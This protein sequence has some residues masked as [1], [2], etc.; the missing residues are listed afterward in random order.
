M[1]TYP[2]SIAVY[3][4]WHETELERWLSDNN[5]PYPTPA[6][7]KDLENL[8]E[9]NWNDYVVEP[10]TNWDVADLSAYLQAKG[11]QSQK[12]V[13]QTKDKLVTQVKENWY[14][15]EEHAQQAYLSIKDWILD[16][17]TESQLKAFC[18]KNGIPAPQPR[19][20]DTLLLKARSSYEA[21]AKKLGETAAY[22]GNWLWAAW[23][24]SEL[25]AW[26]DT[27]G[28]PA[29]Q[30]S[31]RD[32][33]VAS[34]R[35]NSRLAYL[36][37][38]DAAASATA[39]A[40]A[41]YATLTDIIID[42]WSESELK[43]FCD[44]NAIQVPQGTKLNE[45]RALVR[46]HRAQILDEN[47]TG[48]ASKAF[49]AATSKAANEYARASDDASLAA[50]DA[51]DSALKTWSQ[52]RLK[53]YL[54]ARGVPVPQG[55]TM[56]ELQALVRKHS[57]KAASGW[58]AWTFDDFSY[59]NLKAYI[60]KHGNAAAKSAAKKKDAT[61]DDLVNAAQSAY[62]S[63]SKTGGAEYAAATN[64]IASVSEDAKNKLFDTWTESDL[65]A[66]LDS[67]GIPVPQGSK[68]EELKAYARAQYTFFKYG[69]S[70]PGGTV[71]AQLGETAKS[72]WNWVAEQL[73]LG[74]QVAH[75]KAAEAQAEAKA[76]AKEAKA[77]L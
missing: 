52:S 73:N 47:V 16:T 54:D 31:S 32:N 67:Y 42:A 63:A 36:K 30:P 37:A 22:P 53:A 41:T 34:V 60:E 35:R 24:E 23:S 39:S 55:S 18:D 2:N 3:N 62:T 4:K 50:Q 44:K 57:H 66:Y 33:L 69:T 21:T 13:E 17:W 9:K 28:F 15:T 77:E 12:E 51:F 61:R 38:R 6:D 49:G 56:N 70:S 71:L 43:E 58:T 11:H 5:I 29:P 45:L 76:K 64:Y 25:K 26:L 8:V 68:I 27:N 46:K 20:R 19:K 1:Y 48:Q 75:D 65:K 10:F 74:S 72:G 59:D 14:E 40:R 7:R